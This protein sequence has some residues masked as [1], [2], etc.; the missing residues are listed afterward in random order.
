MPALAGAARGAALYG[1]GFTLLGDALQFGTMLVLIRLL[2]PEDYGRAAFGQTILGLM[3]IASMKTFLPHVLQYRDPAKIDWQMQFTAATAINVS[4]FGI[5]LMVAGLL[6]LTSHFAGV[7]LP[8]AVL[9]AVLL[10]EIPSAIRQTMVQV[11]HDWV[12][13]RALTLAGAF[14]GN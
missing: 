2:S 3:S 9:A 4:A 7:A 11:E 1:A 10:I 8:L 5:T 13:F 14:I 12:R 6:S